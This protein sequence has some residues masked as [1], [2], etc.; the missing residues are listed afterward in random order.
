N[1]IFIDASKHFEKSKNQ[2]R[3][4][5]EDIIKIIDTYQERKTVNKYS[6]VAPLSEVKENDYNL[7]IPRYVD[8]FEE[9][10]EIDIKAV[11]G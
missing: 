10:D 1:I 2:N 6:Y 9:E 7:N 11:Q 4:R 3:L 5:K 8:T